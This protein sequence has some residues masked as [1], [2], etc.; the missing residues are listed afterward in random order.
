MCLVVEGSGSDV[1]SVEVGL[2]SARRTAD[3]RRDLHETVSLREPWAHDGAT[4]RLKTVEKTH[5]TVDLKR[6]NQMSSR[7]QT[8]GEGI[9]IASL[10]PGGLGA[11]CNE[12]EYVSTLVEKRKAQSTKFPL[13]PAGP[14]ALTTFRKSTARTK[15]HR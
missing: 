12:L 10:S 14:G 5:Y 2:Y 4:A 6:T 9:A 15:L 11:F 3:A 13:D 8:T 7:Q 1:P